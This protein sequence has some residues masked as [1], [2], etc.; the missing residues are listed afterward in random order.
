MA[1]SLDVVDGVL[2]D[3]ESLSR[4]EGEHPADLVLEAVVAVTVHGG[5]IGGGL[6]GIGGEG[7]LSHRSPG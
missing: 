4:G 5:F 3:P 1:Q 7:R 6:G 2:E